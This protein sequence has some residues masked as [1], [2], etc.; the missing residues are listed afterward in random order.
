MSVTELKGIY[1]VFEAS[2]KANYT[3][4]QFYSEI[5]FW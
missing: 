4:A 2:G 5:L 3:S 1:V